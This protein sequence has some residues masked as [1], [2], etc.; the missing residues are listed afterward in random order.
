MKIHFAGFEYHGLNNLGDQIQSIAAE[1]F[2]AKIDK[3]FNRDSLSTAKSS[4]MHLLIMNGW[5]SHDP[6]NC[7]PT[8]ENI[9]PVFWG[10][11]IF[12]LSS[13]EIPMIIGHPLLKNSA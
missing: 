6:K 1:R 9:L 12:R 3:R 8:N 11:H 13:L 5:F 4:S 2:L 10:F 7:L